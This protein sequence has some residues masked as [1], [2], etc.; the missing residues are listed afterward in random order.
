M[1]EASSSQVLIRRLG[2]DSLPEILVA[3][4]LQV[5]AA[6]IEEVASGIVDGMAAD[7]TVHHPEVDY[8]VR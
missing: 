6:P 3:R 1:V 4:G 8:P 2:V 7:S 5:D